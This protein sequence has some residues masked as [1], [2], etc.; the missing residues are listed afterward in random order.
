MMAKEDWGTFTYYIVSEEQ[1]TILTGD[2]YLTSYVP[3]IIDLSTLESGCYT[4]VLQH[5]GYYGATFEH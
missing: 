5:G 4:F 1:K 2:G 3:Y